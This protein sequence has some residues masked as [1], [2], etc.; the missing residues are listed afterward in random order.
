MNPILGI[1]LLDVWIINF[2]GLFVSHYGMEYILPAIDYIS[3]WVEAIALFTNEGKSVTAFL[4]RNIFS[5][6]GTP[7]TIIIDSSLQFCNKLFKGLFGQI[8]GSP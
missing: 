6:F 8:W 7:R 5:R 4:K 1:E 3:K 2:M